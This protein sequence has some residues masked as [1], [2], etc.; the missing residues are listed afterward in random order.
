VLDRLHYLVEEKG[1]S[2]SALSTYINCPLKYYLRYIAQIE[3]NSVDEEVGVNVIGTIIHDTLELLFADYLP[4][5]GKRQVI[6]KM[7][8]DKEILPKWEQK[9]AL[10]IEK[11]MPNGF[12]DVGFNYLNHVTIEQ[13][14][15]NYLK[16]TSK[17]LEHSDLIILETEGELQATLSAPFGDCLF[18]GRTDRIDQWGGIIRV[19]DYKTGRVENADLKVPV[20]HS[21]ENDL[22]YLKQIPEKAL[23]LLLYQYMYL[24]C[25][26]NLTPEQVSGAIHGLKYANAIEFSLTKASPTKNDTDVDTTFLEGDNFI[27]DMEAMLEAVVA[28]MLDTEI[29]FV[30]AIDDKKCGY[31]EFKLI[32]KR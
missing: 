4:R 16:Y 20:R 29:P 10:S 26:P 11:N 22:D 28:E 2:P 21:I 3:D 13:Q 25:N 14:L 8:F 1:L 19:I 15:K 9:L 7:L 17:Q 30:Q 5:D 24:K 18:K 6:D 12:P 32:C 23:Q 31:C 27:P